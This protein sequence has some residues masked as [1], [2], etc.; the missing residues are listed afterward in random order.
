MAK[1]EGK[2]ALVTGASKGIGAA[3]A[4]AF[5][6]E[7][8]A[9]V[10]TYGNAQ[11]AAETLA[12]RI[13]E[14]GGKA[15]AIG[16]DVGNAEDAQRFVQT[17]IDAYG[18]LDILVNS[19]GVYAYAPLEAVTSQEFHRQYNTNVLGMLLVTQAA[20]AHLGEGA[21][22]INIGSIAA[23]LT[24][25]T[26]VVY[27]GTKGAV[28]AMTGVLSKELAPRR[29]RVNA[30]NPG[31]TVTEGTHA[32]GITGSDFE[33]SLIDMTPLGRA[34]EPD[35]VADVAVFLASDASRW[36]SGELLSVSGGLR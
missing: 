5:A 2:V 27:A 18:R 12:A 1:L 20:A 10:I 35:D 3:I 11:L 31:Y 30:I 21:S 33:K 32:T 13:V 29:I 22:V 6:A 26:S 8:A 36:M 19:A 25:P 28:N 34:G 15:R 17:A 14:A 4:L 9:V 23:T 24:V 7:G 16:G